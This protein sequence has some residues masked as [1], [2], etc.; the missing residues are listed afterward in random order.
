LGLPEE[1]VEENQ[2]QKLNTPEKLVLENPNGTKTVLQT[3]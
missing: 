2:N 3:R 1:K